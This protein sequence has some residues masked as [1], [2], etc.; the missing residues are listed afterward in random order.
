MLSLYFEEP[1]QAFVNPVFA[2]GVEPG[3]PADEAVLG[4]LGRAE[5]VLGV[6]G[7][8]GR[9]AAGRSQDM[10]GIALGKVPY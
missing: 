7:E 8:D 6:I 9:L 10:A 4:I 3:G 2:L 1:V 5:A